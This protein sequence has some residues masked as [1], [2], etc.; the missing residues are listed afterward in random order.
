MFVFLQFVIFCDFLENFWIFWILL[1]SFGNIL[2]TFWE[3]F[4][5]FWDIFLGFFLD[6]FGHI[7]GTFWDNFWKENTVS[8]PNNFFTE[9]KKTQK[10]ELKINLAIM[11]REVR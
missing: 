5:T 6:S 10:K 9:P 11:E 1:E 7:W 3:H 8:F 4:G 2:G